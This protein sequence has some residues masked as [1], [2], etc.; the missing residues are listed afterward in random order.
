MGHNMFSLPLPLFLTK[1]PF[2]IAITQM[3]LALTIIIINRK[4]YINGTKG[5]FKGAPNM[6]TLVAL[7]SF[8]GFIYSFVRLSLIGVAFN[9]NNISLAKS[10]LHDLYFESSAMILVLITL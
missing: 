3:V 10:Y 5:L 1:N 6:D 4:F 7:G 9:L 2:L 8:A